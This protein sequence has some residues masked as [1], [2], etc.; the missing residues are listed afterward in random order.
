MPVISCSSCQ[1]KLRLPESR[2]GK[3]IKCPRC[4]KAILALPPSS[5]TETDRAEA[6][7]PADGDNNS[8][9]ETKSAA[10]GALLGVTC[11]S[12]QKKLKLKPGLAGKTIK[13]PSCGKGVKVPALSAPVQEE[14]EE[15]EEI[16]TAPAR[17]S[18]P[19][20]SSTREDWGQ[21]ILEEQGVPEELQNH[22]RGSLAREEQVVWATRPRMD[23]LMNKAFRMAFVGGPTLILLGV[24]LVL[25]AVYDIHFPDRVF[26]I[27]QWVV[28]CV[29]PPVGVFL[30]FMP[31]LTSRNAPRRACYV[32]T[33]RRLIIHPG[34]G[35]R[36]SVARSDRNAIETMEIEEGIHVYS[37]L[38]L[39]SL[40]RLED[41]D[42]ANA[43]EICL[44]R[45]IFQQ[46]IN[47]VMQAVDDV[48]GAEKR[49]REE[50]LHPL[51]EKVLRGKKLSREE[52]QTFKEGAAPSKDGQDAK[53][54]PLPG[55][56]KGLVGAA[57]KGEQDP[58][59]FNLCQAF[60]KEL[61][62]VHVRD[63]ARVEEE[64][65]AGETILWMDSPILEPRETVEADKVLGVDE[66]IDFLAE[67]DYYLYAL[68][69][70]RVIV[71]AR[72]RDPV[73]YYTPYLRQAV[74]EPDSRL[75]GS[76][77]IILKRVLLTVI[78]YSKENGVEKRT[79]TRTL[80]SFGLLRINNYKKVAQVLVAALIAPWPG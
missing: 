14:E 21:E 64:L 62:K 9:R 23:I 45:N 10:A 78:D 27:L 26:Q 55:N 49:I 54:L 41:P 56:L 77:N 43:G 39:I 5:P 17:R 13:C 4:G 68:T 74:L 3:T 53:A 22:I 20:G 42:F 44:N 37:G 28:G 40:G 31:I 36:L 70:R 24:G 67:P 16:P 48:Q 57:G 80:H 38:Q 69:D 8:A 7:Q 47:C 66:P 60:A 65:T 19:K 79:V 2:S 34:K 75:P 6:E 72:D 63:R 35:F 29:L 1:T 52:M 18:A 33:N 30:F 25:L 76:G 61:K 71:F 32:I 58:S 59:A 15:E 51:I 46:P 50:L 11:V 12:C 73:S